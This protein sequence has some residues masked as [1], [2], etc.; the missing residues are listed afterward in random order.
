MFCLELYL[1][2]DLTKIVCLRDELLK[3]PEGGTNVRRRVLR[4]GIIS[5]LTLLSIGPNIRLTV[6][7]KYTGT[8]S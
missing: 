7:H 3:G 6:K 1:R 4:Y 5:S 8:C 2:K